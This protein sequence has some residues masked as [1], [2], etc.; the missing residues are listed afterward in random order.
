[1]TAPEYVWD[2]YTQS[3]R[4]W[5]DDEQAAHRARVDDIPDPGVRYADGSE[6]PEPD[7]KLGPEET[8][9]L[10]RRSLL[11]AILE[12]TGAKPLSMVTREPA[13]PLKLGRVDAED[14]SVLFGDG[15]CGKGTIASSWI[16]GLVAGGDRVLIVDY[17]HHPSEWARRIASLGGL[18]T[19][20]EVVYVSPVA[21]TW[22]GPRGAIWSHA[23]E[24]AELAD[25]ADC[26]YVVVDSAVPA[27]GPT[28][29]LDPEAPGQY[30]AAIA[31]IG[32]P[33]LTLAH[34]TKA[35]DL[36][37]PFGS[38]FWHNLARVT[39]SAQKLGDDEGHRVLLT[40][41]KGNNHARQ[42][43][44]VVTVEWWDGLPREVSE[45][46][47]SVKLS[48]QLTAV[49]KAGSLT[50]AEIVARINAEV[51]DDEPKVKPDSVRTTL[52]RGVSA[53][54]KLFTVSGDGPSAR[55]SRVA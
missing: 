51:A 39:W 12:H 55:W 19:L 16:A 21:A 26:T 35:G 9:D 50:V 33:S 38:V 42:G 52:R 31:R 14:A 3:S 1:M 18:E 54:P 27:C 37:F 15:G 28:N 25:K 48:E 36:R 10:L 2:G 17:E 30:F 29:P 6:I 24:L 43:R 4:P 47:Y 45:V 40:H 20:S 41:R 11:R 7:E 53:T 34:A 5:S 8:A 13:P 23:D 49:L 44:H 22:N 46:P 32:L